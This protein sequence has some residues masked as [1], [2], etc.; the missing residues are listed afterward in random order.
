MIVK[1]FTYLDE[2]VNWDSWTV[3]LGCYFEASTRPQLPLP[4]PNMVIP[5]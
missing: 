1:D 2:G 3:D 4:T 5:A